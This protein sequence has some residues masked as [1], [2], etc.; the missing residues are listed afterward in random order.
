MSRE[1]AIHALE[2]GAQTAE[3]LIAGGSRF[4]GVGE[5]GIGVCIPRDSDRFILRRELAVYPDV[6][7][8]LDL[9][10]VAVPPRM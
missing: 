5:I 3:R 10:G 9:M 4:L 1:D 2:I 6:P 8:L 7:A